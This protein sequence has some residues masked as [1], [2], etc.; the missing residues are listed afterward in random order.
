MAYSW[1]SEQRYLHHV[2]EINS[3]HSIHQPD[4]AMKFIYLGTSGDNKLAEGSELRTLRNY[5]RALLR[6]FGLAG[7]PPDYGNT[8][9]PAERLH[10]TPPTQHDCHIVQLKPVPKEIAE[11]LNKWTGRIT[12]PHL[13][14]PAH[15]HHLQGYLLTAPTVDNQPWP[16]QVGKTT[17]HIIQQ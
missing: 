13:G 14:L 12:L 16:Q 10:I 3:V 15:G 6:K 9:L 8:I 17:T 11:H 2:D 5:M 4:D 1:A 7:M